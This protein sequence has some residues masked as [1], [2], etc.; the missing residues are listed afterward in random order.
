MRW[1]GVEDKSR[2]RHVN[3]ARHAT[4]LPQALEAPLVQHVLPVED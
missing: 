3:T 2:G 4:Y 1:N